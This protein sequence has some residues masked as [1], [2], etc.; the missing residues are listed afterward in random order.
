MVIHDA[1]NAFLL[2]L[3]KALSRMGLVD[4]AKK[5]VANAL[6]IMPM[7]PTPKYS[8]VVRFAVSFKTPI[9]SFHDA[10]DTKIAVNELCIMFPM[11]ICFAREYYVLF[12][13]GIVNGL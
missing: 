10:S 3:T 12:A 6:H 4:F 9:K 5:A 11:V 8:C 1:I 13:W 7:L 2:P